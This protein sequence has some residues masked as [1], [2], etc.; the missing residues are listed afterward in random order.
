MEQ[1]PY[2]ITA[3]TPEGR[4][5][6]FNTATGAFASLSD[7]AIGSFYLAEGAFAPQLQEA[8]F[9]VEDAQAE[10]DAQHAIFAQQRANTDTLRLSIAPTYACN[11]RCAYCYEADKEVPWE[12]M[13]NQVEQAI[14]AFVEQRYEQAPFEILE[15]EW[16][17]GD[18]QLCL[19][20]VARMAAWFWDFCSQRGIGYISSML[21]NCTRIGAAEAALIAEA[22][23]SSILITVDGP[24]DEHNKRRPTM[25]GGNA[26]AKVKEAIGHLM[27]EGVACM[28]ICNTDKV[29][30][31]QLPALQQEMDE[32]GIT[33]TAVKLN[34]YGHTYGTCR[35]C[36]P[37][38]DLFTHEEFH[39]ANHDYMKQQGQLT[40]PALA[41]MLSASSRFCNGQRQNYFIIDAFGDVYKCDGRMGDK[42]YC[43]FNVVDSSEPVL[44]AVS[45]DPC[46][47][48]QC[49][50]CE[51]LPLCW[52][53]CRWE[54]VRCGMPC[55]PMKTCGA[56]YLNDYA[57]TFVVDESQDFCRLA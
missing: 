13:S 52:G 6:L 10:I 49:A 24:Q 23:V 50:T 5:L 18:P 29:N 8:G 2:T 9:L 25:E 53:N 16:Y 55:H 38:F 28:V 35:F 15:V 41:G 32:L 20:I 27:A 37:D 36:Q 47:D 12:F 44:D 30:I 57:E 48:P 31:K 33:V 56:D 34:D 54:R 7:A 43:L 17:G 45:S 21:S 11:C 40:Q 22:G 1:S 4:T 3:V 39:Q 26:Y 14:Y 19:D 46:E 42:D 51:L